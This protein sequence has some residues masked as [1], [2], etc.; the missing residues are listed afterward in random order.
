MKVECKPLKGQVAQPPTSGLLSW[1]QPA[2]L[3]AGS[4]SLPY[5]EKKAQDQ[6]T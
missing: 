5:R 3:D 4:K 2:P 1:P 6:A